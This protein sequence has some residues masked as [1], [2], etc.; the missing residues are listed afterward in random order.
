MLIDHGRI[1]STTVTL[2]K[3]K[4]D[5]FLYAG[6]PGVIVEKLV[7]HPA[8]IALPD[9]LLGPAASCTVYH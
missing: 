6:E 8:N 3:G 5:I 1:V 7:L 4:N 2:K 9:S